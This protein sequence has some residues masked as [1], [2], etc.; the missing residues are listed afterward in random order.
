[1]IP[2]PIEQLVMDIATN[3]AERQEWR[4][5]KNPE[6]LLASILL[7]IKEDIAEQ[8]SMLQ[9]T[10]ESG[11]HDDSIEEARQLLRQQARKTNG[12]RKHKTL[13]TAC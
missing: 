5:P 3:V 9:S 11:F 10:I 13:A 2:K 8:S 12:E 1:M 7:S 4:I 6:T